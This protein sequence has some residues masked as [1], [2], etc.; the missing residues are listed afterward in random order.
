MKKESNPPPPKIIKP[1]APPAP[2][3]IEISSTKK[4]SD[5]L[6]ERLK[7]DDKL[8]IIIVKSVEDEPSVKLSLDMEDDVFDA[9]VQH[10]KEIANDEDF[11]RIAF[12][13]MIED[14]IQTLK[15]KEEKN[16]KP[17]DIKEDE[18]VL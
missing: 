10:G 5:V 15:N 1:D 7:T 8:P 6:F 3:T 17:T 18:R 13:D 9:F 11:F 16:D 14:T 2:P 12:R 4:L